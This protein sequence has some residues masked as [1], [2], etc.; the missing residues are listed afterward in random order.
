MPLTSF[1]GHRRSG[2][3]RWA[4]AGALVLGGTAYA[5]DAP[6]PAPSPEASPE[7]ESTPVEVSGFVDAYYLYNFNKVEPALRS[8]DIQHNAFSL[9]LAEV[10]FA[11]GVS[12]DSRVGFRVDLDFG[13]TA[14]IVASFE[15]EPIQGEQIYQ[16]IQ[17]AYVSLFATPKLQLD[18]GKYVTPIGAEVIESKDNWNYGRSVLFGYAIPFYHTGLR[19]TITASDKVSI[20]AYV[21]NGWNNSSKIFQGQPGLGIGATLKPSEKVTWIV[22][23]MNGPEGE[24]DPSLGIPDPPNRGIFDTTLTL[25]ATDKLSF[26]GNFDYGK[27]GDVKWWGVA[28]YVKY[29]ATPNWALAGRY[30]YLDDSK[31]GFMTIDGKGQTFTVTSDHAIPGGLVL[32]LEYYLDTTKDPFFENSTGDLKKSQSTLAAGVVYAFGGKI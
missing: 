12:A 8:F 27:E 22:N 16:N 6:A 13:K 29:Q 10:A 3:A 23:Y 15:P 20:G 11:K 1:A 26:M 21:T 9:S 30:E 28:A 25:T 17:Q 19:A 14:N 32:R 24:G 31:G 18:F 2:L 7:P 5:Q 4:L